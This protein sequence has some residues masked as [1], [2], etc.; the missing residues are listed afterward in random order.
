[1]N[2]LLSF[3]PTPYIHIG[4]NTVIRRDKSRLH[5]STPYVHIGSHT[6]VRAEDILYC[7]GDGNYTVIHFLSGRWVLVSTTLGILAERLMPRGFVRVSRSALVN[8]SC[9][10]DYDDHE[11]T[12]TNGQVLPIARRRRVAV[13]E[14]L[15]KRFCLSP[16]ASQVA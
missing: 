7:Q 3:A 5:P 4:G 12:L 10:L 8:T 9:I 15:K 2:D 16:P 1:M 13:R 6:H 14:W 11:L